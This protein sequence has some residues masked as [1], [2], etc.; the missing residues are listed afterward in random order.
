MAMGK[1]RFLK[2]LM[3]GMLLA[4]PVIAQAQTFERGVVLELFTGQGCSGCPGAASALVEIVEGQ[5]DNDRLVWMSHHAGYKHDSLTVK[6]SVDLAGFFGIYEA[7]KLVYNRSLLAV[8]SRIPE[9][10][11]RATEFSSYNTRFAQYDPEGRTFIE[12]QL[13][14]PADISVDIDVTYDEATRMMKARVYGQR[15]AGLDA[16]SPAVSVWLT[17]DI[18][19]GFQSFG[20]MQFDTL[21]QHH[22]PVRMSLSADYLGDGI[23]FDND[24]KW[25]MTYECHVPETVEPYDAYGVIVGAQVPVDDSQLHVAA[26]VYNRD[27]TTPPGKNGRENI[28]VLNA[29]KCKLGNNSTS[30]IVAPAAEDGT[31]SAYAVDGR[32]VVDGGCDAFEVYNLAGQMVDGDNLQ[33]GIYLVR[34]ISDGAS[35]TVKVMVD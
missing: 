20:A 18:F 17:Q 32:I 26:I 25:E 35:R 5:E 29:V 7:P 8:N 27:E 4:V 30:A 15:G 21:Y 13:D 3:A 1:F 9:L 11:Q 16:S 33:R 10:L 14:E 6:E 34:V 19:V 28:G 23:V 24:G 2:S 22:N 31:V 12:A